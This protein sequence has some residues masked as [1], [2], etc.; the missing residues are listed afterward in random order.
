MPAAVDAT[1][2]SP[3]LPHLE[4]ICFGTP[5]ARLAGRPAPADVLWR[6]NLALLIYLA[7]SP[8]ASRSRSQVLGV[9]WPEKDEVRAR[10]SLNEALHRLRASLGSD[11]L[12]SRGESITLNPQELE[13]DAVQFTALA[14]AHASGALALLRGDFLEG[15]TVEDAPEFEN[16]AAAERARLRAAA[17]TTLVTHGEKMLGAG[18]LAEAREAVRRALAFDSYAEPAVGLEMRAAA[19]AGDQAGALKA[20]HEFAL[21]LRQIGEQPSRELVALAERIRSH[22]WRRTGEAARADEPP[23][24][25][26]AT[27]LREVARILREGLTNGPRTLVVSG[28]PG[29]GKT[30]L[31]SHCLERL[32]LEGALTI[33]ARLLEVDQDVPWS[34]LRTL[35]RAGLLQ[36]PGLAAADPNALAVLAALVPE[37]AAR[38]EA[39]PPQDRGQVGAALA[40]LLGAVADETSLS[41]GLDQAQFGDRAT[42]G[43]LHAAMQQMVGVP[44]VLI[45]ASGTSLEGGPPELLELHCD[46]GRGVA[47]AVVRLE[48]LTLHDVGELVAALA[49]WCSTE[50]ER[51]RLARRIAFETGGNPFLAVTMLQGLQDL[52]LL[53]QEALAWPPPQATLESPLPMVV[54]DLVRRTI[55]AR[56]GQLDAETRGVL[57][58]A[59]VGDAALDLD[60]IGALTGLSRAVLDDHLAI[61]ER[62]RFL[63]FDNG[64]YLFAAPLI[65]QVVRAEGLTPG[66][67]GGIRARAIAALGPRQDLESRALR[68]EL[69]ART[70]PGL[71]TF[72]EAVAVARAA[73]AAQSVRIARRALL[74]AERAI[75]A[76]PAFDR[77]ELDALREL[78]P[79]ETRTRGA[80][81]IPRGP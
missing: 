56:L 36:A 81:P 80:P 77:R 49:P 31:L 18:S 47:G 62:Q 39:R 65:E 26:R 66:Q 57:G 30:R 45:L 76:E 54:P 9:L 43:A 23:L 61:L 75:E 70:T 22:R 59:S 73:L 7:L 32:A 20:Y 12:R 52:V 74:A 50:P 69:L 11:R 63:R 46:V 79:G 6:K 58:A 71:H 4:L 64:R 48:P 55:M 38:V 37:L 68:A 27:A 3:D 8:D 29:S 16:W 33:T 15:F 1:A 24:V 67:V 60:L 10:H 2:K 41:L 34:T 28:D 13:V 42:L 44:L 5:T 51:S 19:L 25:G 35:M 53:R 14:K 21:F 40:S 17:A 72:E 78:L